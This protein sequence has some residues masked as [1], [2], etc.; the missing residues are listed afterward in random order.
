[1]V[2]S[3]FKKS[4]KSFHTL[5]T[6]LDPAYAVPFKT[7]KLNTVK[8]AW[9]QV[10]ESSKALKDCIVS[11]KEQIA[12]GQICSLLLL[13]WLWFCVPYGQPVCRSFFEGGAWR[14]VPVG[15]LVRRSKTG[16]SWCH[17]PRKT[18]L[19]TNQEIHFLS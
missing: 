13:W 7:L 8:Q 2:T 14:T 19:E 5:L 18:I 11:R 6:L 3:T 16:T 1:M 10:P 9:P 4:E 12:W 15:D 17:N